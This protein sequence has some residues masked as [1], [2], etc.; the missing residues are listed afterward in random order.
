MPLEKA[1]EVL[2][3]DEIQILEGLIYKTVVG[4]SPNKVITIKTKTEMGDEVIIATK[5]E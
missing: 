1:K 3:E 5:I 4:T 2:Q